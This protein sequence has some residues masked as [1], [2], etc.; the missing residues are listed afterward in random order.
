LE[1]KQKELQKKWSEIAEDEPRSDEVNLYQ[2][3]K[4]SLEEVVQ[5]DSLLKELDIDAE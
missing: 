2:E 3:Y 5:L 1:K 4:I